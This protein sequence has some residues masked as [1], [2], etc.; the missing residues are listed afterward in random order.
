[1]NTDRP[2][3]TAELGRVV[4]GAMYL[5][6]GVI[7]LFLWWRDPGIYAE[8][9]PY[10]L[11]DWYRVLWTGYALP[12]LE[13]LLPV[14]AGVELLLAGIVLN[15]RRRARL[16]HGIGAAFQVALAPLGFWWPANAVLAVGH[17]FLLRYQFPV[18]LIADLRRR[19]RESA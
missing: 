7:H 10:I 4:Y 11:F 15:Q 2:P 1:M 18:A 9:T 17:V 19:L 12:N 3:I 14:L 13:I 16:G 5:I 8:I 6:G